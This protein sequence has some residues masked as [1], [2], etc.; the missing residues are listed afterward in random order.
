MHITEGWITAWGNAIS[1]RVRRPENYGK[2]LTL[3]YPVTMLFDG[4]ALRITLDNFCGTQPVTLTHADA[5]K[6]GKGSSI[7]PQTSRRIL[8]N[9]SETVTI[10]AGGSVLS[11]P[12]PLHFLRG[13]RVAISMY[14]ADFTELRSSVNVTG[15]LSEGFFSI[16][17]QTASGKLPKDSTNSTN[18]F[19]FLSSIEAKTDESHRAIVCYGDSITAQAWP[20]YLMKRILREGNGSVSIVRKAASGSRIL[21]QYDNIVYESYGLRGELRFPHEVPNPGA[22][23]VIIQHGINDI[24]HPVGEEINPFRPWSDMPTAEDLI[25]GTKRYI[26]WAKE[27]GMH[28]YLGTLLP[29][30]G[31]RTYAPFRDKIR[32]AFNDWMRSCEDVDGCIDF[33]LALRDP[34]EPSRFANGYDSGDHLHPSDKAYQRMAEIIPQELLTR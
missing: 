19:Y 7:L 26:R 11:D 4:S 2:D 9:G 10:P 20:D 16:G 1:I 8:F 33:D 5:A 12:V 31:W 3:R 24:I 27:Y 6:S 22:D 21:R 29:I 32:N 25:E 23:T 13:E 28:V 15:P 14:F 30:E 17:D 18:W 34:L